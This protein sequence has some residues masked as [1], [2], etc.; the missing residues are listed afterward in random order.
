VQACELLSSYNINPNAVK[1][2]DA[3]VAAYK[4]E[5]KEVGYDSHDID[6]LIAQMKPQEL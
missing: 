4:P 6:K 5:Y 3:A 1:K 2:T